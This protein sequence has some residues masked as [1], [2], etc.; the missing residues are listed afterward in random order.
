VDKGNVYT[1][2]DS[3]VRE[4]AKAIVCL[5]KDNKK[6]LEHFSDFGIPMVECDSAAGAVDKALSCSLSGDVVLLS[7][8]CAS[9]DLFRN[10]MDRGDQFREAVNLLRKN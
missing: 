5:G 3:L 10:Y 2:L 1:M 7:P 8:A 4:K 9:F 6:I